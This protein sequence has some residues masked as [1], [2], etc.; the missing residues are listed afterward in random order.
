MEDYV[1]F[2]KEEFDR[3]INDEGDINHRLSYELNENSIIIDAGGYKG[4]WAQKALNKFNCNIYIF[5]PVKSYYNGI[6]N[7]FKDNK[8]VHVYN[9]GLSGEDKEMDI[10]LSEDSSSVFSVDGKGTEKIQLKSLV[11][12]LES[13]NIEKVDLIKINIEGGEY[14]L[15]EDIINKGKAK[16]FANIQVQFH[17]FVE[18][19]VERRNKIRE[20]I[21]KTH[22]NTFDYEF[23]WEGWKLMS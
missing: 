2:N 16:C 21:A 1:E 22:Q 14:D 18:D 12:F 3:W 10:S 9:F 7:K 5:E 23:I 20:N 8:K 11:N 15:L 13:N 19:C 6:V 17:R 4:E